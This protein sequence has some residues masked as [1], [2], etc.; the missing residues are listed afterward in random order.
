MDRML[1]SR[2]ENNLDTKQTQKG[3]KDIRARVEDK[4]GQQNGSHKS[5][6]EKDL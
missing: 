4:A 6:P 1:S 3:Q 2:T 5:C